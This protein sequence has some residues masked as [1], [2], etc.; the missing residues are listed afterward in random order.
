MLIFVVVFGMIIFIIIQLSPRNQA[1]DIVRDFYRHEQAGE[2]A[3][4]WSL[5]H[6]SMKNKFEKGHYI[7]DRPHVFMNHFGVTTFS[8][9]LSRV[10]K[11]ND[12]KMTNDS[13]LMEVYAVTV[14]QSFNGKYGNFSLVQPVYVTK[15]EGVWRILWDYKK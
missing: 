11:Y 8:F 10:K 6:S 12:W 13:S 7:H 14:T 2:F 9:S 5:F 1:K 3:Q 4:S 15:E